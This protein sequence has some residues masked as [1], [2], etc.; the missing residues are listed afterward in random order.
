[1]IGGILIA[2]VAHVEA[3]PQ[4]GVAIVIVQLGARPNVAH[5]HGGLGV[6]VD[7]AVQ[8]AQPPVILILQIGAV[9]PTI[10]LRRHQILAWLQVGR[11]V[12]LGG[13]AAILTVADHLAVDPDIEGR[14]RSAKD[15]KDLPPLPTLWQNE[16]GAI[17]AHLIGLVGHARHIVGWEGILHIDI[18]RDAIALQLPVAGHGDGLPVRGI[19]GRLLKADRRVLGCGRPVE[20]PLTVERVIVRRSLAPPH[21]GVFGVAVRQ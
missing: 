17:A 11:D 5:V 19:I 1:M 21:K 13:Q 16:G 14:I 20:L 15:H 18:E 9:A 12:E 10:D 2:H 3:H 6:E 7:L 4:R 8:A